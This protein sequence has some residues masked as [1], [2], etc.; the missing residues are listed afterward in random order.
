M[1]NNIKNFP[2]GCFGTTSQEV[3]VGPLKTE[4]VPRGKIS[5]TIVWESFQPFRIHADAT[6]LIFSK[7]DNEQLRGSMKNRE[8]FARVIGGKRIS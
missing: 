6:H 3:A 7:G 5:I 4:L 1:K 8:F 2:N